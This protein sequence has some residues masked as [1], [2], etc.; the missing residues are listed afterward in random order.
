M[1]KVAATRQALH[2]LHD[3]QRPDRRWARGV[4]H[5]CFPRVL[6]ELSE[7]TACRGPSI[8]RTLH[9]DHRTNKT[10]M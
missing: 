4:A 2:S 8:L 6:L 1:G 3:P 7:G 10:A 5:S 9:K